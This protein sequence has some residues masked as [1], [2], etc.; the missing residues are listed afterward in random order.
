MHLP[1]IMLDQLYVCQPSV[2]VRKEK[3]DLKN[4]PQVG[5]KER[6]FGPQCVFQIF[7]NFKRIWK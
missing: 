7:L 3:K 1:S 2:K 4:Q 5:P 6:L